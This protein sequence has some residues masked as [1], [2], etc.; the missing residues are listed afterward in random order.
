[1]HVQKTVL[2]SSPIFIFMACVAY[3]RRGLLFA[4]TSFPV[5]VSQL[6]LAM[7]SCCRSRLLHL[8]LFPSVP[9]SLLSACPSSSTS[10]YQ[11]GLACFRAHVLFIL[12]ALLFFSPLIHHSPK[13]KP[14]SRSNSSCSCSC[15]CILYRSCDRELGHER[16]ADSTRQDSGHRR[17]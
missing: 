15:V 5:F 2:P 10:A 4:C 1:M 17:Q 3:I 12:E 9:A 7:V 8:S 11:G 6:L 13:T 16:V 14:G